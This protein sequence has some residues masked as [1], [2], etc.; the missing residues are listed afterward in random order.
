MQSIAHIINPVYMGEGTELNRVQPITFETMR[1]AKAYAEGIV[2]VELCCVNYPED[3]QIAPNDFSLLPHLTRSVADVGTFSTPRKLPILKD[4]L[5]AL[6]SHSNADYFVYT[7]VDIAV[8]PQFYS[9]LNHYVEQGL[10]SFII[11]RRRVSTKYDSIEQLDALYSDLGKVHTG[12]DTF[13]F[14]R[15][16]LEKFILG[17]VC[18]GIPHVG[19]SLAHNLFAFGENFEILTEKHLTIHIGMELTKAWGDPEHNAHNKAAFRNNLRALYPHFNIANIPGSS[20]GFFVRHFKWL[21]N[22]TLHYPTLLKLD[23]S[24]F[25]QK[26]KPRKIKDGDEQNSAYHRRLVRYVNFRDRV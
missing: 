2:N 8:V 23:F 18:L 16:L 10:D 9:A 15:E 17:D 19:N 12:Y 13:V 26:R 20:R 21:M 24:Q 1:R 7:N 25:G 4:I 14:K 22:P 6:H 3:D 11:N 5:D